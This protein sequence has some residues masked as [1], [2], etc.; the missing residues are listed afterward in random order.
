MTGEHIDQ[1]T[2]VDQAIAGGYLQLREKFVDALK[3]LPNYQVWVDNGADVHFDDMDTLP[4]SLI[5][6]YEE[7][8]SS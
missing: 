2:G 5:E 4:L 7:D 6:L 8:P 3:V 1:A